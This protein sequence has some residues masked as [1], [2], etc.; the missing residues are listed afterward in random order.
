M[1]IESLIASGEYLPESSCIPPWMYLPLSSYKILEDNKFIPIDDYWSNMF[2]EYTNNLDQK[3]NNH[4]Y[5]EYLKNANL[6]TYTQLDKLKYLDLNVCYYRSK[7]GIDMIF[8]ID[9]SLFDNNPKILGYLFP[10]DMFTEQSILSEE[11]YMRFINEIFDNKFNDQLFNDQQMNLFNV[12]QINQFNDDQTNTINEEQMN[13]FNEEQNKHLILISNIFSIIFEDVT[14]KYIANK[15]SNLYQRDFR[16]GIFTGNPDRIIPG[17]HYK[18]ILEGGG[19]VRGYYYKSFSGIEMLIF[20]SSKDLTSFT[21]YEFP[22][23]KFT[24]YDD[25]ACYSEQIERCKE[26]GKNR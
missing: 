21:G 7:L 16:D 24:D 23:Y 17:E 8:F 12:E 18:V 20:Q 11:S 26:F 1:S 19:S 10:Y 14:N 13:R 4:K 6:G 9:N 15:K 3:S 25:N 2:E 5:Y 22:H